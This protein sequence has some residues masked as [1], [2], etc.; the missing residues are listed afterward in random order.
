MGDS[1]SGTWLT[2]ARSVRVHE[3]PPR[4]APHWQLWRAD[5]E[6]PVARRGRQSAGIC[7][8]LRAVDLTAGHVAPSTAGSLQRDAGAHQ[9]D[10]D[11]GSPR[12]HRR[13]PDRPDRPEA[14]GLAVSVLEHDLGE[15]LAL[16]GVHHRPLLSLV[17]L[18]LAWYD[19]EIN[20]F[21]ESGIAWR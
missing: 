1:G 13:P 7:C 4:A 20:L 8:D 19:L 16:D 10:P 3:W 12:R 21:R 18:T 17:G 9:K 5:N 15:H 2:H 6:V 14:S 11:T